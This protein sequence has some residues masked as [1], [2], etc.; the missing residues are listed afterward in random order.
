MH[1]KFYRN[2]T[3]IEALLKDSQMNFDIDKTLNDKAQVNNLTKTNV[4][5][6]IRVSNCLIY[7][8]KYFL[9]FFFTVSNGVYLVI[10]KST[11]RAYN[12]M[13]SFLI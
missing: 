1:C 12:K 2:D 3:D 7:V 10:I 11:I 8:L 9:S 6:L 13:T 5:N 4:K